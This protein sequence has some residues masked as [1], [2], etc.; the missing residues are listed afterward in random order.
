MEVRVLQR[1]ESVPH[2]E[3]RTLE[4]EL[5]SYGTIW[6]RKNLLFI[7]VPN[8]DSQSVRKYAATV[9]AGIRESGHQ[10][11]ECV[12]TRDR[13]PG[14]PEAGVLVADKWGEIAFAVGSVDVDHLPPAPE[15]MEWLTY[16]KSQCPECEGE[17]R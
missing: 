10:D 5:F 12:V 13:V 9:I 6:Q 11:V 2:F 7:A 3:V 15:L 14:L 16:V 17:A 8:A 1:G 4:D